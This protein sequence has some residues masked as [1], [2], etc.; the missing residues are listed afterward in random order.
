MKAP[1]NR[2]LPALAILAA[3][4]AA[5]GCSSETTPPTIRNLDRPSEVAFACFGDME[6]EGGE[7][8]TTAQTMASCLADDPADEGLIPPRI[9]GFV[10]QGS[11]GTAAVV[12]AD[13]QAVLDSDP[14]TPGQ[15]AIPITTLPVGMTAD[16]SGCYMLTASAAS[17]DLAALDVTS[18]LDLDAAASISR[19]A[20]TNADGTVM[21][22][23][24]RTVVAGPQDETVGAQCP[25]TPTGLVYVAYP[26]CH[27]V[28]V[29]D[30]ATGEIQAGVQFDEAG[31]AT[32]TDGA[33]ECPS[34]CGDVSGTSSALLG[35]PDAGPDGGVPDGGVPDGGAPDGGTPDAGPPTIDDQAPRPVGLRFAEDGRLYVASENSSIITII[36]LDPK[37]GLPATTTSVQLDGAV[38]VTSLAVSP[39]VQNGGAIGGPSGPVTARSYLYAVATD[40]TVRVVDLLEMTECDTQVDPRYLYGEANVTYLS[41]IPVG[42][43]DTP[44]RR[45][46]ARSPGI[47]MPGEE[48]PL[49]VSF[50][51]VFPGGEPPAPSGFEL[52]GTFAFISTSKGNVYIA[53]V[54]DDNYADFDPQTGSAAEATLAL[55]LAHQLRDIGSNRGVEATSCAAEVTAD[56]LDLSPRLAEPPTRTF[57]EGRI[58]SEKLHLMPSMRQ[59][60]CAIE[61]TSASVPELA[62]TAPVAMRELNFPDWFGVRPDSEEWSVIYEGLLSLDGFGSDVDGPPTRNGTMTV[63]GSDVRLNDPAGSFCQLGIEPFDA[64][65][66]VGC[67]PQQGDGGCGVGE[68]CFIH[69]DA[70][71]VVTSGICLPADRAESLAAPCRDFLIS[72]RVYAASS[73]SGGQVTLIPRKRV[74][75]TTP[76]DG[77]ASDDQCEQMAEVERTLTDPSHPTAQ[78][79]A[80]PETIDYEWVCRP[81]PTRAPGPDR[82]V[83]ACE[84]SEQCEEGHACLA[85]YCYE[86]TL[87]TQECVQA[88]QRYQV[89]ASEAFVVLSPRDGYLHNRY[90]DPDSGQCLTRE[91][92]DPLFNP[93]QA[94]RIPL[95]PP[96]CEGDGMTDLWPN[97]CS[98]EVE[99]FESFTVYRPQGND[100]TGGDETDLRRR[101]ARAIRL[102]NPAFRMHLV[103]VATEGDAVCNGDRDGELPPFSAAYTGFELDFT[104][105]GGVRAAFVPFPAPQPPSLPIRMQPSPDG[106]VWVMDAGDAGGGS[107]RVFTFDPRVPSEVFRSSYIQ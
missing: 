30:A 85:G 4:I 58:A 51:S 23:K 90:V 88:V 87:P 99:Q 77:C 41:C 102:Q 20:I 6:L 101:P 103:D 26:A 27:T 44:P 8:V 70:P 50:A 14:L 52:R 107:G 5:A 45:L 69:P 94:G 24:P 16:H 63:D 82:C 32:I 18:A 47:H 65:Q 31:V 39:V 42:A 80:P 104:I 33:F 15:N 83:M 68:T 98:V 19:Y 57:S 95:R 62:F 81:E 3:A 49:D 17:C 79:E 37:T 43:P 105:V 34:E 61:D 48:T 2:K 89:R 78:G 74:L 100:C 64:V 66:L 55:A 21:R 84:T 25:A 46:S 28:A 1:L 76:I 71:A 22:A 7:V 29:V 10:L 11:R 38:G 93:L 54:D 96:P 97:P 67:D 36:A 92:T 9:Y 59:V 106:R 12:E 60:E 75:R 72:R 56:P 91:P 53:N 35:G 13:T 86:S 73:V 40:R